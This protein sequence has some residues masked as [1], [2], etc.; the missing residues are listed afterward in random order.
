MLSTSSRTIRGWAVAKIEF[1]GTIGNDWRDSDP[2]WPPNPTP[3]PEAPNVVLVVLDDVG[4]AQ[5]GCYG[6]DIATPVMDDLAG[7]GLRLTNFHTTALCS[8]TRACLLTGRN[9]HRSGMGR[10]ADLPSGFPGYWA[11]P[12]RENGFLS[13]ALRAQGYATYAVG[14]WHLSPEED[15]NMAGSRATWP[16]G[17]GFDRWYGF[18][19]GETHQFAPAL[20]HDNHSVRPPRP[21]EDGYHLTTDLADRAIEFLGDLRAVDADTPF[22]LYF[23]TGACHSPHHAP[24]EWI[25]RYRDRFAQGWDRWREETFARQRALGVVPDS[26]VLSPRPSWVPSWDSLDERQR[27]LA[28]RFMECFAAFLSHTDEQIGRV[29]DFILDIGEADNTV[30]IVVSDNGASSEGGKDG[31]I[32]EGRLSNFDWASTDEMFR[33]IDEIGGPLSHNNYPWGWTM[34]GNTPFRR[35]KR[36]VHEG[37]VADPCIVRLPARL[38]P[39]IAGGVRRQFTHA[40]D[41]LPTVLELV[42]VEAP[43]E[44]DGVE[45]SRLDGTS[46]AYLLDSEGEDEPERHLTQHFEMLGSRAIYHDGWKAVT[47]H[48]VGPIYDD[49][50]RPNAPFDEDIWELYHVAE[51]VSEVN[52]RAADFPEKVEELVA[53]WWAEARRN[54][55]LPLDNRVLESVAHRH[56]RRP[57]RETFRY[58][59]GGAPVPEYVAVD[60]RNRSHRIAVSVNVPG[61]VPPSGVLLALGCALGGWS[62]HFLNGRLRYVHNLHSQ[63]LYEVIAEATLG[64]GHHLVECRFEKDQGAG[65]LTTLFY[66]GAAVGSGTIE[67][68]TPAAFNEVGIGLTCGYEWG[69]AVGRDY[70]A[71]FPFNGTIVRAEVSATGPVVRDPVAEVAAILAQQ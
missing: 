3:P 32:N 65:G 20:F 52:D 50:L 30:V 25:E 56:D 9:H 16:L 46:F 55:V 41:I 45:Q 58:F 62:L 27:A 67:R 13:E 10:V 54:D 23:A 7:A 40:I 44:L 2:W 69:P 63:Y 35:W 17:R 48:P 36:E 21:V 34:A 33:R 5:L 42:G 24:P 70:E 6:S 18:H 28:E 49:G 71:P 12:P 38:R 53:L 39:G 57:I 60:V 59:P 43:D 4:F 29:L 31:T 66:D 11:R 8:P 47:Y 51:D 61:G 14:K 68:F 26:A 37:G 1:G 19:G 15:T 64:A 22:F